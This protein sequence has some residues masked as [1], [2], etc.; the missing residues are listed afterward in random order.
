MLNLLIAIMSDTY[1]K[2]GANTKI[3]DNIELAEMILE[4]EIM[5]FKKVTKEQQRYL[6]VCDEDVAS[7]KETSLENMVSVLK[8][9]VKEQGVALEKQNR[10]CFEKVMK[11]L[12]FT[13]EKVLAIAKKTLPDEVVKEKPDDNESVYSDE[14]EMSESEA[15]TS[16]YEE[17]EE[18]EEE[19][20]EDED[21]NPDEE[22]ESGEE[23]KSGEEGS[24]DD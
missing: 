21:Y 20:S 4:V 11:Q 23:F 9:K 19:E 15:Y 16:D 22:E 24:E 6:Q 1:A 8:N 18:E 2:V 12:A 3:A 5:R 14:F 10:E 13:E 17:S 7:E